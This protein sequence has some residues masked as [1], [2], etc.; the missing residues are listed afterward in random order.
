MVSLV[1]ILLT[2]C[3]TEPIMVA[4]VGDSITAG[5]THKCQSATSY[6]K[7]I[8][9]LLGEDYAVVNCGRSGATA[10]KEGKSAYFK[11]NEFANVFAIHPDIITIKLG[12]NDSKPGIWDAESFR[13]NYQSL[14]DTFMTITP[15]PK[16]YLCCP[17]PVFA[18]H[19]F[20][21][22]GEVV[23]NEVLPII[24]SLA[25]KNSLPIIDLY[26]PFLGKG[27]LL[28]DGVHPKAEGAAILAG[29]IADQIR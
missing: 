27:E 7:V 23:T 17:V 21:I 14:I 12:T 24:K 8:G 10:S 9:E 22:D 25:D 16:I 15:Q 18:P 26:T 11:C 19:R 2:S 28:P 3:N 4:C 20:R 13:K 6:P 1:L 5:A 29:I